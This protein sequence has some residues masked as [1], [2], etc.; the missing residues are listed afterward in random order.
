MQ[1]DTDD[2]ESLHDNDTQQ[3]TTITTNIA[4]C[5]LQTM[6]KVYKIMATIGY[7]FGLQVAH[8]KTSFSFWFKYPAD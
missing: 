8:N 3:V 4:T 6:I 1:C 5:C 7:Q 2:D